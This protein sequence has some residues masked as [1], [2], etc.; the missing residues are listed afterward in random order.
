MRSAQL[1]T[2]PELMIREFT[3]AVAAS[4]RFALSNTI[5]G[6]FRPIPN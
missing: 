4:S 1:Q 5:A 6:A 2:C 3:T